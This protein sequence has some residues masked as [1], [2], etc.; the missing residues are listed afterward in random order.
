MSEALRDELTWPEG[1]KAV[2]WIMFKP[3]SGSGR[4]GFETNQTDIEHEKG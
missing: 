2:K 4:K 1:Y 3:W